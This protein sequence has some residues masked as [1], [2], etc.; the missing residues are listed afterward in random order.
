MVIPD[1]IEDA[2]VASIV[3]TAAGKPGLVSRA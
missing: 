1:G 2:H 3:R